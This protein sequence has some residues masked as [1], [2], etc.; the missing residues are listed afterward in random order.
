MHSRYQGNCNYLETQLAKDLL[1]Y[2]LR[3]WLSAG[4]TLRA[5][6]LRASIPH[7]PLAKVYVVPCHR[8]LSTEQLITAACF[9]KT[10]NQEELEKETERKSQQDWSQS[11]VTILVVTPHLFFHNILMKSELLRP[12]YIQWQE[13]T[14][15]MNTRRQGSQDIIF[16]GYLPQS[17]AHPILHLIF[18]PMVLIFKSVFQC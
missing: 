5:I 4:F 15:A 10:S 14:Q 18:F 6:G 2:S 8:G 17:S 3:T 13:I 16:E 11:S 1:P 7:W 12:A 9:L